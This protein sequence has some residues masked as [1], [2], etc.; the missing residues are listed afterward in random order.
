MSATVSVNPEIDS[1]LVKQ[2]STHY[3]INGSQVTYR[4]FPATSWSNSGVTFSIIPPSMETYVNRSLMIT[5]PLT[6]SYV[7]TTTGPALLDSG[8]DAL[9]S[10]VGLRILQTQNI[11]INGTSI[12]LSS[13]YDTYVDPLIHYNEDYRKKHPLG[14]IDVSQ[15]Y[16]SSAGAINNPLANYASSE[17][18]EASGLKRGAYTLRSITRTATT[19]TIVVD[20][21]EWVY[22]PALFGADTSEETGLCRCRNLDINL[23]IDLSAKNVVSHALGGLTS[24][25]GFSAT[26]NLTGQPTI[27]AK[28]I[29]IPRD[30]LPVGEL[31]Y[32]HLRMERFITQLGTTLAPNASSI[33]QSNNIQLPYVPRFMWFL[34]REQDGSKLI[35]STDTFAAITNM[36]IQFNNQSSLLSSASPYQLWEMSKQTGL[37]DSF[38]Q[39]QGIT[40][41]SNFAQIGAIG[42]LACFELGR[43]ISLGDPNL[44]IGSPGSFNMSAQVTFKNVNQITTMVN[45]TL[46]IIVGYD[47]V[48]KILDGGQ[49][50]FESPVT[51]IGT[52]ASGEGGEVTKVP[53]NL[54]GLSGMTTGGSAKSF[55]KG[56]GK[57]L[58]SSKALSTGLKAI[59]PAL[60]GSKVSG[61]TGPALQALEALGLGEGGAVMSQETLRKKV[62]EL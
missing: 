41:T 60:S 56:L 59:A 53:Y 38:V 23:T 26:V 11:Q 20:V 52:I 16:D 49:I 15:E 8:F 45:P 35:T 27:L 34:I 6:I 13:I 50:N 61:L 58:K 37:M 29:T 3:D 57:F 36:S 14:A 44:S 4:I 42:S 32:N 46:Y 33:I 12:P 55:F 51:P 19:A 31:R 39:F 1:S 48:M 9:R 28:F 2:S 22:A 21:I 40:T 24:N 17:S 18:F 30:M 10:L 43:H 47:Q 7:G 62:R 54:S 25:I 5:Y